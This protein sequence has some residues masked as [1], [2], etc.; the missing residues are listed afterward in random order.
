[1]SEP[2]AGRRRSERDPVAM[3]GVVLAV[4]AFAVVL[5]GP[6]IAAWYGGKSS[7]PNAGAAPAASEPTPTPAS[8]PKVSPTVAAGAHAFAR[9]ACVECH[10]QRGPARVPPDAPAPPTAGTS[11]PVSQ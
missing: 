11:I 1:M 6:A 9:F 7:A 5:A 10:R 3:T 8:F 2:G 4:L